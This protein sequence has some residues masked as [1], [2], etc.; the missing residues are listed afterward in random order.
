[1]QTVDDGGLRPCDLSGGEQQRVA[2]AQALVREPKAILADEPTGNLDERTRDDTIRLVEELWRER[3]QT[4]VVVT[5]DTWIAGRPAAARRPV[6]PRLAA[7]RDAGLPRRFAPL[8]GPGAGRPGGMSR[9]GTFPA[10]AR[11][12]LPVNT[13]VLSQPAAPPGSTP[14]PWTSR[15]AAAAAAGAAGAPAA[16]ARAPASA[17]AERARGHGA[18]RRARDAAPQ[19]RRDGGVNVDAHRTRPAGGRMVESGRIR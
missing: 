12:P 4:L 6:P 7:A 14:R 8:A 15:A 2:I 13:R 19:T 18:Q 5:H 10:R 16:A 3:G 9:T 17:P 1:V 11:D